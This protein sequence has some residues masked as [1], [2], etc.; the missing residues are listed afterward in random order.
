MRNVTGPN[1]PEELMCKKN[2]N[3]FHIAN[4]LM[5]FYIRVENSQKI[6]VL[7]YQNDRTIFLSC[8]KS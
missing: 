4:K 1:G 5:T 2:Y 6:I 7:E 8:T 3:S